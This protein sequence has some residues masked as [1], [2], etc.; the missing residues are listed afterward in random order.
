MALR[1]PD[2]IYRKGYGYKKAGVIVGGTVPRAQVQG[3]LFD[4][5]DR[6]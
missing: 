4:K 6:G 2:R 3:P 1:S 5:T